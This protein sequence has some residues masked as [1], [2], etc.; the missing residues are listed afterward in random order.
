MCELFPPNIS[1]DTWI[2][3]EGRVFWENSNGL[4]ILVKKSDVR[5]NPT[6][7]AKKE[8]GVMQ[9]NKYMKTILRRTTGAK[10][11]YFFTCFLQVSNRFLKHF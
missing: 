10:G 1:V 8:G 2:N 7:I 11:S 4:F 5:Y 9:I 6:N 3:E